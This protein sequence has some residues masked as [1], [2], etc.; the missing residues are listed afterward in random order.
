MKDTTQL[1][2]KKLQRLRNKVLKLYPKAKLY[3]SDGRYSIYN[4]IDGF[5]GEEFFIPPQASEMDA[6]VWAVETLKT[7]QNI[8]R[9]HP[10]KA[11]MDFD[12]SRF[13]RV[14]KRNR[15]LK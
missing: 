2:Q 7:E 11:L 5:I 15:K 10:D 1:P 13:N 9:T 4:G 6:W 12:E 14:S 3:V 8:N